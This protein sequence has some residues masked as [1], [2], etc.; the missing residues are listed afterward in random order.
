MESAQHF[1]DDP[2]K[3]HDISA[4]LH[5]TLLNSTSMQM[6]VVNCDLLAIFK[7]EEQVWGVGCR[8]LGL[9]QYKPWDLGAL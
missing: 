4:M 5:N 9:S 1:T 7:Y 3:E 6:I 2:L 8:M